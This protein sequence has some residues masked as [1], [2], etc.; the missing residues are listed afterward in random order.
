MGSHVIV[1]K[2]IINLAT[3]E[4]MACNEALAVAADLNLQRIRIASDSMEVIKNIKE[5]SM[6]P[7][8]AILREMEIRKNKFYLI[9]FV[10]FC[11]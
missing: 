9:S 11:S 8:S 6:C 3:L 4:A 1:V 5:G 7:Y 10:L 2:E